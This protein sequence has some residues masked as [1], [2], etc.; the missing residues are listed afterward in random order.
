MRMPL[1]A[2]VAA[3]GADDSV[4]APPKDHGGVA[5]AAL[6]RNDRRRRGQLTPVGIALP[7]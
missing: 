3:G 6:D 4:A 7:K 2:A 5:D 1:V